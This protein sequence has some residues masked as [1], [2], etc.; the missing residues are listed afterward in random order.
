MAACRY[1]PSLPRGTSLPRALAAVPR[2]T[3]AL[4]VVMAAASL[5]GAAT[6]Y[7]LTSTLYTQDFTGMA[8]AQTSALPTGWAFA[9][10]TS[11]TWTSG[12]LTTTTQYAGT[13]GTGTLT[14]ASGGGAYL[15]IDGDRVTGTDKSIGFLSSNTFTSPRSILFGFTNDTGASINA[16]T[17]GWQYEKYRNGTRAFDWKFYG[18]TDG[19]TW[20]SV[21]AGDKAYPADATSSPVAIITSTMSGVTLSGLSIGTSGAYYVRWDY[22]GLAGSSSGQALGIDN[23]SMSASTGPI[24]TGSWWAPTASQGIGGSGT[25][26]ASAATFATTVAGTATGMLVPSGTA[27]FAG[28]AGTVT[29]AGTVSPG[30]MAFQTDAYSLAGGT[31]RLPAGGT[32][33]ASPGVRATIAPALLLTAGTTRVET[34][35]AAGLVLTGAISGSGGLW[36]SGFGDVTLAADTTFT[37]GTTIES[38]WLRLG[39]GGTTGVVSENIAVLPAATLVIDR[40]DDLAIGNSIVGGGSL[41][42]EGGNTVTLTGSS[43]FTGGTTLFAGTLVVGDGGANGSLAAAG[44]LD[45]STGTQLVFDRSDDVVFSGTVAGDGTLAQ[46]GSGRLTLAQTGGI[47]PAFTLRAEQGV[48]DLDRSGGSLVGLLGAGNT[49]DLA[50]GTL[51]LS[52]DAG[53]ETK[54]TGA[55]IRVDGNGTIAIDRL[56]AAGDHVTTG[57]DCPIAVITS[58]TLDFDFRGSFVGP[59]LPTVRYKGTTTYTAAVT[60]EADATF[61]VTNTAGGTAEVILAGPLTDEGGGFGLTKAGDEILTLAG[62]GTLAGPTTVAEGTLRLAAPTPLASSTVAV[63]AGATLAVA[64]AMQTMV[65]GLTIAG[66]GLVDV[67]TGGITVAAGMT[68]V[69]LVAEILEGRGDGSWTGTSGITSTAVAADVAA[70]LPRAV[71]WLAAGGDSV[72]FAYSAPGDTNIDGQVDILDLANFFAGG[73]FNTGLAAS[74]SE[75]DFGYDGIV[76]IL[77]AADFVSTGLFNAGP[78]GPVAATGTIAAVPE[79]ALPVALACAGLVSA[80]CWIRIRRTSAIARG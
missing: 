34:G 5:A 33:S 37:G 40:S 78:Y 72:A 14:S 18:S 2:A 43:T 13:I 66:G 25:W 35:S 16:L 65:G 69:R 27:V 3:V 8:N 67:S 48:V 29:V 46:V 63:S 73:K 21:A 31:I 47:G 28:V 38:G 32:I 58:G 42:K 55:T 17:L 51:E 57:F 62:G 60:L 59:S 80:R 75:G 76:D 20:S 64:P 10:G 70:G 11:P 7:S 52:A 54:L 53:D 39:V 12:T 71:G 15:F 77:D 23:L 24:V 44:P 1:T 22:A 50:G 36:V 56:G 30:G 74:W 49:V 68:P 26:S 6:P 41:A 45:L 9:S 61:A 4:V 79:P 19:S